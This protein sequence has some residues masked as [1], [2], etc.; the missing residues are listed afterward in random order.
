[1]LFQSLISIED[2]NPHGAYGWIKPLV[3][4]YDNHFWLIPKGIFFNSDINNDVGIINK[5]QSLN[6]V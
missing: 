4:P 3:F 5:I 6:S 2:F 1:M